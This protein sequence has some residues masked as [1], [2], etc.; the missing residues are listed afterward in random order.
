MNMS[1]LRW[2]LMSRSRR[3]AV[4]D[5]MPVLECREFQK[6]MKGQRVLPDSF[7]DIRAVY[8]HVPKVAGKSI[9]DLFFNGENLGHMSYAWYERIAPDLCDRFFTFSFVRNPWDRLVSAYHYLL[10]GGAQKR[11]G[12][13]AKELSRFKNFDEFA[14]QWL[15]EDKLQHHIHFVPQVEFLKNT[16]G[17]IGLDFI[18]RFESLNSDVER[19]CSHLDSRDLNPR[20]LKKVNVSCRDDYRRYYSEKS[21]EVVADLYGADISKFGYSF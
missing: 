7:R 16:D 18:G 4:L 19:V 3:R 8:V 9:C 13:L 2:W 15:D 17:A 12:A 10:A 14:N 5:E 1:R 20:E 11:D 6:T 21:R